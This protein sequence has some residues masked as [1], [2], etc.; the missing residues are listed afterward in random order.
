VAQ[1]RSAASC[2]VAADAAV[3]PLAEPT[4]LASHP[5]LSSLRTLSDELLVHLLQRPAAVSPSA[6][7]SGGGAPAHV[8]LL[9]AAG[10]AAL[11][12]FAHALALLSAEEQVRLCQPVCE[13]WASHGGLNALRALLR[14]AEEGGDAQSTSADAQHVEERDHRSRE[15]IS[16]ARMHAEY[17]LH[18]L[19][20]LT[21]DV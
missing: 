8:V 1:E 3:E 9:T 4:Q 11:Q 10:A 14:S 19:V 21:W 2:P 15:A 6:S 7:G 17:I 12:Q 20:P 16:S 18:T 13:Q 5:T